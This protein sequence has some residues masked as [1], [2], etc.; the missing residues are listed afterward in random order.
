MGQK[1]NS[2]D[3][4]NEFSAFQVIAYAMCNTYHP[5]LREIPVMINSI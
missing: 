4:T 1:F 2:N 5:E 3:E